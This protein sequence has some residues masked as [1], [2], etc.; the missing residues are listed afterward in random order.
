MNSLSSTTQGKAHSPS[1]L[2]LSLS[3]SLSLDRDIN[4]VWTDSE[5]DED[6]C[7]DQDETDPESPPSSQDEV[8]VC[9]VET[10]SKLLVRWLLSFFCKLIFI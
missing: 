4:E 9:P 1:S 10:S 5:H 7:G 3:L 6:N 2:F 8:Q